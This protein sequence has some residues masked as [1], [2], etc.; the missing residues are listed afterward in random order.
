MIKN[1]SSKFDKQPNTRAKNNSLTLL[2]HLEDQLVRLHTG[3][4]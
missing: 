1:L 4:Q 2:I 3:L